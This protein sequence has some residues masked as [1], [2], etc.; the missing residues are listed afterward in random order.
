MGPLLRRSEDD[1]A[2]YFQPVPCMQCEKAPCEMVCPVQA[3]V[4]SSEGLNQMVYN[5]CV[6]T[7]Y[8]SANCPYG[9]RRFNFL[10]FVDPALVLVDM[11]NPDV[12]VR[13]RGVMEKC[14]CMCAAH[15]RADS[16]EDQEGRMIEGF[17]EV[18]PACAAACPLKPSSSRSQRCREPGGQAQAGTARLCNAGGRK[19]S[20]AH[21]VPQAHLQS[22]RAT[23]SSES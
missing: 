3:T 18:T 9:V 2:T 13:A 6:G 4:H 7:R 17:G 11:R 5:R 19:C 21:D 16:G 10:D 15:R 20:T 14:T 23:A 22:E 1:P 8:C 12:T